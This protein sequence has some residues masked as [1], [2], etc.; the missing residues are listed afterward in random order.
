MRVRDAKVIW[1]TS[2]KIIF[3]WSRILHTHHHL[4]YRSNTIAYYT[5]WKFL[6]LVANVMKKWVYSLSWK[7]VGVRKSISM[8]GEWANHVLESHECYM[9]FLSSF[10]RQVTFKIFMD[11]Q[12]DLRNFNTVYKCMHTCLHWQVEMNL[13][14]VY[15]VWEI[16]LCAYVYMHRKVSK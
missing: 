7:V 16:M 2:E 11:M 3:S 14:L 15:K 1:K 9:S 12:T 10:E 8:T 6:L 13:M 4:F 5:V